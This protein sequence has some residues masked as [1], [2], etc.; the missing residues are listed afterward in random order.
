M[1]ISRFIPRALLLAV[2]VGAILWAAAYRDQIDA[3][4]LDYWLTS[5]GL[6]APVVHV[7]LF[8]AGTIV[9]LPGTLFALAGGALFG[10]V[11][12]AILNLLGAT[13]GASL[14]FLIARYLVGDWV[15]RKSGGQLKRLVDGVEK[16]GWR[17]VAFVRLVP[18]FPFNL[19]NYALGLTRIGFLPYVITSFI[20]MAPGAIAFSW[21][22]HAGQGALSGDASAI[23]YGLYALGLLAV[24]AF[25]PR[26]IKQMRQNKIAWIETNE[27]Q[28]QISGGAALTILD[29]R[30][31]DEFDGELGHIPGAVNIPVGDI[32]NRLTE[33][34][35]LG[36]RP[37]IMVCKTDKR[38]ARAAEF[39]RDENFVDVRVLR[40]GME[41]WNRNGLPVMG[42]ALKT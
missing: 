36:D 30:G 2:I 39:L 11:W 16:E 13:I 27:L 41:R 9:F 34:K 22:G 14:A 33:I 7:V 8:A 19:T 6:W 31:P 29:V 38:S 18:L 40:G 4:S 26:L 28:R 15:A 21:L 1:N 10:P 42:G 5:L 3:I 37:V 23:R 12:G 24:I 25:V 20:C 35:A 32:A 17:F